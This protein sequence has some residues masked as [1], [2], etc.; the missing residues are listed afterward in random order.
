VGVDGTPRSSSI[1]FRRVVVGGLSAQ[2]APLDRSTHSTPLRA[3]HYRGRIRSDWCVTGHHWDDEQVLQSTATST[4]KKKSRKKGDLSRQLRSC[5]P[6]LRGDMR[7]NPYDG[8][9]C[10]VVR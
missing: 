3:R 10:H 2:H 8:M 4:H 1:G 9:E 5:H 7:R 6:H